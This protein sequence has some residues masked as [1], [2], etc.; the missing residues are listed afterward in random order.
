ML[1]FV[2][3]YTCYSS[4]TTNSDNMDD[5]DRRLAGAGLPDAYDASGSEAREGQEVAMAAE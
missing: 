2:A 4:T 5:E 1:V 3:S